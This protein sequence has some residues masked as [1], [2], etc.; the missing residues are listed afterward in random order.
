MELFRGH[1]SKMFKLKSSFAP[2]GDQPKAIEKLTS[3][4]KQGDDECILL[5]VTG[6]GKTFT[7]AHLIQNLKKKT[8]VLAPNKTLAAQLYSEFKSFFPENAVEY[9]VSYY[10]YYQPEAYVP[11][12]DTYIEKD[13]SINDEID[14]L[15]HSTT[16]S[17][18]TRNDVIVVSSVSC[19]YGIGSPSDYNSQRATLFVGESIDRDDFLRQLVRLQYSRNDVD[20]YRGCFRVRGDLVEVFPASEDKKVIRIEFFDDEVESLSIV[21]PL[22]GQLVESLKKVTIFPKS[23]YVVSSNKMENAIKSIRSELRVRLKELEKMDKLVEKQRLETRTLLDLEMMEE[24]GYCS[25]IENYSRHLTGRKGGEPPPTLLDYF[26]DDYLIVIDESHVT[27][28]QVGGMF[29]GDHS[30]K[31]NLV[32]FGFRLP[33]ALDN[34]PLN[35]K[36]FLEKIKKVLYVSATPGDFELKRKSGEFVDQIIRPTGLLDPEIEIRDAKTQV[37]D[38]LK[39]A[40]KVIKQGDRVLITALTKRL[41]EELTSFYQSVGMK[42]RYLHSDIETLERVE[43]MRD[44]R[45][46]KFDILVGINLLREGLDIPEVSLVGIL[47]AD[48][49][50][51]LRSERSLIQ[52]IGR[53][54]RNING[55]VILYAYKK[56]ASIEK[57]QYETLRRRKLQEE[58]NKKN[59][60]IPRTIKKPVSEGVIEAI[61]GGQKKKVSTNPLTL[62]DFDLSGLEKRIKELKV[63]MK[64]ASREL[65]FEDAAKLRDEIKQLSEA[66]LLL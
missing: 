22:K 5:G 54:A 7:T 21:D 14:K 24:L 46:G 58:Y 41:A 1:S 61:R 11:G 8:L 50:G 55:K 45:L 23:H 56:T 34:R 57:A 43:I 36:E 13:A 20:F 3:S 30:R 53:A 40:K 48:K 28:P 37:E 39:E 10:D 66:R 9:F 29:K 31:K 27:V 19:I 52:T 35:F 25:G 32:D 65:R 17:L 16:K 60:L 63:L 26:G 44:L 6:S 18:L 12:S 42:V 51:F 33:S 49:E 15:R 62:E 47:D 64:Q 59:N 2:Y 4:F 38:L